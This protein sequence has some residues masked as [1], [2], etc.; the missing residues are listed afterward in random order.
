[1]SRKRNAVLVAEI[2]A[3]YPGQEPFPC[4]RVNAEDIDGIERI[5][6]ANVA[7]GADCVMV[8]V[9]GTEYE[10]TAWITYIREATA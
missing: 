7:D 6:N 8:S 10:W 9:R 3:Y 2:I 1:M 5:A 4:A